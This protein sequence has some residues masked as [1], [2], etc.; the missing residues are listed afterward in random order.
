MGKMHDEPRRSPGGVQPQPNKAAPARAAGGAPRAPDYVFASKLRKLAWLSAVS[1]AAAGAGGWALVF[2]LTNNAVVAAGLAVIPVSW[3]LCAVYVSNETA[4]KKFWLLQK[5]ALPRAGLLPSECVYTGTG[6]DDL[7]DRLQHV[8]A[9]GGTLV[10]VGG[11]RRPMGVRGLD[12]PGAVQA[13]LDQGCRVV[14][15]A[16]EPMADAKFAR[17]AA[18]RKQFTYKKTP[19]PSEWAGLDAEQRALLEWLR[20]CQPTLAE[21]ADGKLKMVWLERDGPPRATPARHCQYWSPA[22]IQAAPMIYDDLRNLLD[23]AAWTVA[24]AA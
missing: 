8:L 1:A 23:S 21:S 19:P 18:R 4:L 15:C 2:A 13:L 16:V 20:E 10:A 24:Q 11:D 5:G 6:A 22:D 12:W 14:Q 9:D 17:L 7:W 3:A